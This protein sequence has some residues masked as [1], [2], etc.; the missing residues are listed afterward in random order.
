MRKKV[1]GLRDGTVWDGKTMVLDGRDV[2]RGE[3]DGVRTREKVV[4]C[5][6]EEFTG[7]GEVDEGADTC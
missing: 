6:L 5:V 4:G 2:A 3:A 7:F 1:H